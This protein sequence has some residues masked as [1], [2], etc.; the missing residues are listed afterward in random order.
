MPALGENPIHCIACNLEVRPEDMKLSVQIVDAVAR[1]NQ[2]YRAFDVLWLDS[3]EYESLAARELAHLESPVNRRGM[4]VREMLAKLFTTFYW[5]WRDP[6]EVAFVECP[7]CG[8][9]LSRQWSRVIPQQVCESCHL[10][11]AAVSNREHP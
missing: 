2:V 6:D 11:M 1:W 8:G 5:V 3:R 9:P 10:V 7:L 4:E